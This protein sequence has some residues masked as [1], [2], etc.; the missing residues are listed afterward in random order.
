M[1][2]QPDTYSVIRREDCGTLPTSFVRATL[3][4]RPASS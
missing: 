2:A 4:G 3:R 1:N